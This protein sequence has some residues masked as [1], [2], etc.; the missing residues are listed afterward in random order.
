MI[1]DLVAGNENSAEG[2]LAGVLHAPD[3]LR[4]LKGHSEPVDFFL[5][6]FF[7]SSGNSS[8]ALFN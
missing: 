6:T 5:G 4:I 8:A 7:S 3:G 2:R 1:P